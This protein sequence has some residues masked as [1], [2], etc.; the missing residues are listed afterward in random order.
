M[1][2]PDLL[3][4]DHVA[5][6]DNP[7]LPSYDRSR[8]RPRIIH[9]G[10][11]AFARAHWMSYHQDYLL[12]NPQSDWGVVVCGLQSSAERLRQLEAADHLYSVLEHSDQISHLRIIGSI[13]KTAHPQHG[14]MDAFFAP[15]LEADL[16]IVSLTITEKGYCLVGDALDE[17]NPAILHDLHDPTA[18]QSA[19]GVLVEALRRRRD[20]GLDGFSILSLDNLPSNGTLCKKAVLS[21]ANKREAAL[22]RW[23]EDQVAFPCS[24][25]DRIV[26]AMTDESR[27]LI[28][29]KLGGL[30]DPTAIVCEP[31]RQWVIEDTFIKGRPTWEE[32]GVEI[33]SD[34]EPF[35]EM[36][37]RTLNGAHSFLAYLGYLGGYKTIDACM[38]DDSYR[39]VAHA[40]MIKEQ[41]PTL[42]LP[43]DVDLDTYADALIERFSNSQLHHQTAQIASD[44]SQ[45]LPQRLLASIAWHLDHGSS[46]TRLAMAV[47]GWLRF[48]TGQD[49]QGK[50]TP[51]N[52]PL[53]T[54]IAEAAHLLPDWEAYIDAVF[55]MPAI[56]PPALAQDQRFVTGVKQ[57]YAALIELGAKKHMSAMVD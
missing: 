57:Q 21:F 55:A 46:W 50:P 5:A 9:L 56:F 19:I 31:F 30:D 22:A 51:I 54:P 43:G 11:G 2:I 26:P 16:A 25:V 40:L 10:F 14:G 32:V 28:K 36:K 4:P 34:V 6:M 35:E 44:G 13:V 47:A 17:A 48:M 20:K 45:K 1:T 42:H 39:A 7:Q 49:E 18:P 29:E 8:L 41:Q 27:V 12:Q 23:I 24:M 33:V 52:D 15:F 53:A 3:N 38:A 37:L